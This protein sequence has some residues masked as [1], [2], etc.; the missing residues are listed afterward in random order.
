MQKRLLIH[1]VSQLRKLKDKKRICNLTLLSL[2]RHHLIRSGADIGS[3]G[4]RLEYCAKSC[5]PLQPSSVISKR[6]L[7]WGAIVKVPERDKDYHLTKLTSCQQSSP[8]PLLSSVKIDDITSLKAVNLLV[9][10]AVK[11]KSLSD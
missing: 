11:S 1:F 3:L 2:S 10:S 9:D 8:G 6:R 5:R 7:L 4:Y